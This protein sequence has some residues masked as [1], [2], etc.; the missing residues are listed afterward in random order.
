MQNIENRSLKL[1]IK[2]LLENLHSITFATAMT[3]LVKFPRLFLYL[4][5]VICS[6]HTDKNQALSKNAIP[7]AWRVMARMKTYTI[8]R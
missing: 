8:I 5:A 3:A 6:H 1:P 7:I 2:H 4:S